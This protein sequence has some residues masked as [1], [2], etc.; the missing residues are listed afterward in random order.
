MTAQPA[1]QTGRTCGDCRFR[2]GPS[3]NDFIV[4]CPLHAQAEATARERDALREALG[5]LDSIL[6]FGQPVSD[7][8]PITIGRYE[9]INE[10][11]TKAREAIDAAAK[12][13]AG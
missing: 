6:D 4:L 2:A 12:G 13:G 3:P 11:F 7:A 1:T 5:A 10:A 8:H 9:R